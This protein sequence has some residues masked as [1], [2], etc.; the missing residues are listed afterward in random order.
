MENSIVKKKSLYN[1]VLIIGIIF[2]A[3]NLRPAITSIG[4][5]VGLIQEDMGLAH[6]SVSLLTS[7]PLIAFAVISPITPK[8]A[9][10]LSNERTLLVGLILILIGIVIRTATSIYILF[11]GTFLIGSGIAICNVLLPVVIK[12]KFPLK[13]GLMTSVYSTAM[14]LMA[15]VA[16]GVTVPLISGMNVGWQTALLVWGIPAILAVLLWGYLSK[17]N[18]KQSFEVKRI[19]PVTNIWR[20]LLAWQIA[21]FMGCQSLLF[22]V[23]ITWLPEILR[24]LGASLATAGWLLSF[25]Q[26]IGL[27]IGFIVPVLASRFREQKGLAII[28]GLSSVS[29]FSGLLLFGTND[30]L[31]M[32]SIV[33]IGIG[34]G[35]TFP[36]GLAFLGLRSQNARQAA[37]LSGMAQS[38]GYILAAVGPILIGSIYDFTQTWTVPLITLVIVG[39][40]I[41]LFGVGAGRNR[42]V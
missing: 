24:N 34:L 4:P 27:P 9:T 40:I 38:I 22:Y 3:F 32:V 33:L 12:D 17:N 11:F 15:S 21:L 1:Y 41:I 29:G 36:L 13:F 28:L 7:L 23:T 19:P 39:F 5:V 16:S 2:V 6:W 31:M 37:Q 10:W 35:G 18:K 8:M 14:G 30:F 25:T 20:S 42:F 26:L